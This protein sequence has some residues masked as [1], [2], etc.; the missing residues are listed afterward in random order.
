MI[1]FYYVF[2]SVGFGIDL[3]CV[4]VRTL[5]TGFDY[6]VRVASLVYF[7]G[8]NLLGEVVLQLVFRVR[9]GFGPGP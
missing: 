6:P 3:G 2:S 1:S 7:D 4:E 8:M 5:D 9:V